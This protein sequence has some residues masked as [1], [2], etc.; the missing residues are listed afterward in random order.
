MRSGATETQ[1]EAGLYG[2]RLDGLSDEESDA[3]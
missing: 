1:E 2:A 3:D